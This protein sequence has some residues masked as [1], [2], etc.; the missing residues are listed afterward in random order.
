MLFLQYDNNLSVELQVIPF[1]S[2]IL[3]GMDVDG[4]RKVCKNAGNYIA[5]K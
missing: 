1:I 4:G 5:N 3:E 2:E